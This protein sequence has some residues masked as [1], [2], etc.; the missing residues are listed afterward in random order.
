M[1]IYENRNYFYVAKQQKN[2]LPPASVDTSD[3]ISIS[4]IASCMGTME[5]SLNQM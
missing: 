3:E 4:I 1:L 2:K 5:H